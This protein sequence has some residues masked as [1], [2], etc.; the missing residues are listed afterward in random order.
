MFKY[1]GQVEDGCIPNH[2]HE[3]KVKGEEQG[4]EFQRLVS[5]GEEEEI[6]VEEEEREGDEEGEKGSSDEGDFP[7]TALS[8]SHISGDT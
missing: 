6:A 1:A 3:R 5:M 8:I 2:L 4:E 7:D